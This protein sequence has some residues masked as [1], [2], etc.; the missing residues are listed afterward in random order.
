[1]DGSRGEVVFYKTPER[2]TAIGVRLEQ[3]T[4]WL[5]Q[6]QMAA[7]FQ[8]DQSVVARHLRN[9]F[10]EKELDEK[11]NMQKVHRTGAGRPVVLYSLDAILSVGYRVNSRR[12]TQFRIWATDV[13]RNH[14]VRGYSA[15]ERRLKELQQ[16]LKL[17]RNVID[18]VDVSGDEARSLLEVVADYEYAL[19]LL[20]DYD[21]KR[22]V[23]RDVAE[24]TAVGISLEEARGIVGRLREKYAGSDLFGR[25]RDESLAGS[26]GAVMQTFGRTDLYPSIEAKAAHLL[27]FVVKNHSFADGNKRIAASLFLWFLQKNGM[28]YRADGTKR[29]ADNALVALTIMIAASDPGEKDAAVNMTINLIN[30][31]N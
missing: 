15:N 20:D 9:V 5:T 8:R 1:M 16:S 30:R 19:E 2:K 26:L 12:G 6:A 29:I 31:R 25:E 17:V 18:R 13:L 3:N 4:L 22:V 7:L 10:R 14:L 28:L 21:H 23:P 27:Y 24:R 11:S